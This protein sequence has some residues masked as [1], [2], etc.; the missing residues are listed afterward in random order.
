MDPIGGSSPSW[1]VKWR[2]SM[3]PLSASSLWKLVTISTS[4]CATLGS[5]RDGLYLWCQDKPFLPHY[6]YQRPC[7][8]DRKL[9]QSYM[10]FIK[11]ILDTLWSGATVNSM[12]PSFQTICPFSPGE[13]N[14]SLAAGLE[15]DTEFTN[16][17]SH[18][19]IHKVLAFSLTQPCHLQL[20]LWTFSLSKFGLHFLVSCP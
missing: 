6:V 9:I 3:H 18:T 13:Q 7:Q 20:L 2:S 11:C 5:C 15:C 17:P 8:S 1:T 12:L 19:S 10:A 4:H 14:Y 16:C